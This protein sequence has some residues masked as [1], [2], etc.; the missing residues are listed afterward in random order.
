MISSSL[1]V[2]QVNLNR[3]S[4]ATESAL[5]IAIELGVD[6]VAVQEPYILLSNGLPRSINHPGFIQILP[7]DVSLR[8]R[9]LV[10]VARSTRLLVSRAGA[11]PQDPDAL[12]IDIIED[13]Q[14]VQLLNI[15][16]EKDQKGTGTS[17]L[18]RVL[19]PYR[20]TPNTL[21]L[22]DFNTHH[23]WW[24]P[25]NTTS[26]G[27]D[28]LAEW[29]EDQGLDLINT[30]G[31]GTFFRPHLRQ[32]SVLDLTL[33]T[34]SLADRIQDWQTLPD[35]GSDHYGL[36]FTIQGTQTA[37]ATN[38]LYI[39]RWNT[40]L[41]NWDLFSKSLQ[42]YVTTSSLTP[43][44]TL[45]DAPIDILDKAA[46]EL[47]DAITA[48]AKASIPVSLPGA[49]PKPWWSPDLLTLRKAMM[50]S[51]RY[52][53]RTK[54]ARQ[55]YLV[56]K[57]SYFLAIKR[58]KR[59]HWNSFLEK[60]DPVSIYK[61]MA[62]TKDSRV[63]LIPTILGAESFK[64]KCQTF[65]RVLFPTPPVSP[66]PSWEDYREGSWEWPS[67]S[68]VELRNA[69]SAKIKGKT[70]GPDGI[71]HEI[72]RYAYRAIPDTFYSL[73]SALLNIG[74][75]PKCWRQ[76]TGAILKKQ[77]KPD[78]SVPK[79]YRV[80]ALLNCLGKVSERILA[81]RLSY[82]AETTSLLHPSQIG[83]RLKKSAIDAA[84]LLTNKVEE[85]R[86]LKRY[87][88]ALFLDIK[89][90]FDHVSKN[91]LLTT[92]QSLRLPA[93]L[94]RWV[95]SFLS[96]RVLRLSFNGQVEPF[97]SIETGIPQGSPISPILFLI[98]IRD[99][100]PSLAIGVL[101][102]I[103]DIA[104]YTASTSLKKN[105]KILEREAEKLYRLGAG[106]AVE[107]DLAKTELLHFTTKKEASSRSILLPNKEVVQPKEL[108]RWLGIWFD[109]G[110][111]FK[112][113]VAIR[114]SQAR[115]TFERL[116]RLANSEKGLTPYAMRQLYLA[117]IVSVAD[118]GAPIWWKGQAFAVRQLQALQNL[119]LRKI[120]GTFRT[121]PILPME[122]EAALLPPKVRLNTTIR[123]YA[124][125]ALLLPKN[126]PVY[127]ALYPS[128]TDSMDDL[129]SS[130][131]KPKTLAKS[132]IERI[133]CSIEGLAGIESLEPI[134]HYRFSPWQRDTPYQVEITS[135]N[136]DEAAKAHLEQLQLSSSSFALYSDGSY[137]P[138]SENKGVGTGLAIL[139]ENGSLVSYQKK[140]LGPSQLVYN[141]ELEGITLAIE[142]A[143]SL[144]RPG[145]NFE[146][147]SDNQAAL[148]RLKTPSDAPGQQCQ[149]R[150]IEA[151]S[152]IANKGATI[153][154]SW[155]PGH[156]DIPGN[157][158]ADSLA[159]E[160]TLEPLP[161]REE[162]SFAY[163]GTRLREVQNQEWLRLLV[164][165]G[166]QPD[167]STTSYS[168]LYPWKLLSKI[169]LPYGTKR[170]LASA[171]YQLK[172]G[173]GYTKS[174]L[175]RIGRTGSNRCSCGSKETVEHLLLSCKDLRDQ[176]QEL[177]RALK[178]NKLSLQLLLHTKI[179][180]EETLNFIKNTGLATR[181]WHLERVERE[182]E[183]E[184]EEE[185]RALDELAA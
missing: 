132:Q 107:F 1:K 29:F 139:G 73:Y 40:S 147:F 142:E 90:A 17:T 6:L 110:L 97:S 26:Q 38:P 159:K 173:H 3:S 64:D 83:G 111:T 109:P 44:Q 133:Q 76:A 175:Y 178:G 85:N 165:Y 81:Q 39:Q 22:G 154:L 78:Y 82:L 120:L 11:S 184:E 4:I 5:Q 15:Y 98:Y 56:A 160:A 32:E 47:T 75:H 104:L 106:N 166:Q 169:Q 125:R 84:L 23:P 153:R 119:G 101:S 50:Y 35:L 102:F 164:P 88:S 41:A 124:Y 96:N 57:N 7:A 168:R 53:G 115:T 37:T 86:R 46:Q 18:Q 127:Q 152:L 45:Q 116:A 171:F 12:T 30:P 121:T 69:C 155:V 172:F 92:L 108:V 8:P 66:E 28:A 150:A 71:S 91:R 99:L 61:A 149:I 36:L 179:G 185:R 161:N 54:E 60:E 129:F 122:V 137:T 68:R 58:A 49:K 144:A 55:E 158:L 42:S 70:P 135:L 10:Y 134:Q 43:W 148:L 151:A 183:R 25:L 67:L 170:H 156:K 145:D 74:Y 114:T 100:F 33:A 27:A 87:T 16:N 59:D 112:Q 105:V 20:V 51:Q 174:Y 126:H 80:I 34:S 162:T 77:G 176:R 177:G 79:A 128:P 94:I 19:Y 103:D 65:R 48:A 24:D 141:A 130:P 146:V 72:L 163:L 21:V 93:S 14:K 180:I 95:A 118:Y 143:S 31:E 140:N 63:D 157:E 13:N 181:K 113:H 62:Y 136:K 123:K 9:V 138:N 131:R 117:C 182:R 2:L 89:G 167:H 52:I